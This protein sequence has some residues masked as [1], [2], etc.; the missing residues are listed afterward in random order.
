MS[1]RMLLLFLPVMPLLGQEVTGELEYFVN[2]KRDQY[3]SLFVWESFAQGRL[4]L[5]QRFFPATGRHPRWEASVGTNQSLGRVSVNPAVGITSDGFVLTSFVA[6]VSAFEHTAVYIGDKKWGN[7]GYFFE[8]VFFSLSPN[9][10]A[11][12]DGFRL[13]SGKWTASQF[14]LEYRRKLAGGFSVFFAGQYDTVNGQPVAHTGIRY[15]NRS[16]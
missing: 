1:L 9:F 4:Q 16:R 11:R 15:T 8:K 3:A 6:S 7:K 2:G 5:M 10:W 14:G 13:D 12:W